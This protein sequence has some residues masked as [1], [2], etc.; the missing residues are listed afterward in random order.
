M[1]PPG[2]GRTSL[3]SG[4][5]TKVVSPSIPDASPFRRTG[6]P[7]LNGLELPVPPRFLRLQS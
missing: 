6:V 1:N 2:E 7:V 3:R 4:E 5:Y